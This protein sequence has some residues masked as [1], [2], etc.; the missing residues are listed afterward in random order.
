MPFEFLS[1]RKLSATASMTDIKQLEELGRFDFTHAPGHDHPHRR[2]RS[3]DVRR[4]TPSP[5]PQP[6]NDN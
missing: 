1:S 4:K 6:D 2:R 3:H 5:S